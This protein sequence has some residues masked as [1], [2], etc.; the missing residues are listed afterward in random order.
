MK[1]VLLTGGNGFLG[2]IILQSKDYIIESLGRSK[3]SNI[4]CDLASN[5]PKLD[6]YDLVIHAAGRAH[7]VPK[8]KIEA[9]MFFDVNVQG[10]KNLLEGLKNH[11]PKSFIFISSVSVYGLDSGSLISESEPLIAKDPYG[12]SKIIAEQMVLDWGEKNGVIISIIRLPLIVG[13]NPPGNLGAMINGISKGYYFNVGNGKA[14]KSM[15]LAEDIV[16]IIPKLAFTGGIY[17]LASDIHPSF[18]ELSWAISEKLGK[19]QPR[20]I[21]SFLV[22]L[23][24]RVGDLLGE[25]APINSNKLNKILKDLTFSNTKAKDVLNWQPKNVLE[26]LQIN[27]IK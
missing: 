6:K 23:L 22:K 26:H 12:L 11:L 25:K 8:T 2:R 16:S 13:P 21:P 4:K 17:N 24:A 20:S 19:T 9:K 15:I 1:K 7:I 27:K 3:D 10:T 14:R 5:V 18:K